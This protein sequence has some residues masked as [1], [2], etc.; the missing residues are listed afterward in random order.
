MEFECL[1]IPD[2]V[3]ITPKV[4]GDERGFFMET[5]RHTE[6]T[7]HCGEYI[8]VQDNHSRSR[9]GVLR[10]LHFQLQNPQ[11]KLIQ[12]TQGEVFDVAVD[13]R[14]HSDTFGAWVGVVLSDKNRKMLWVPPGFAHGFYVISEAAEFHYKCTDYYAP[15]DEHSLKWDDA[16]VG[17]SWP[18]SANQVPILSEKDRAGLPLESVAVFA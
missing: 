12:V 6:F 10:G 15:H 3:L 11:G 1:S 18:L 7:K 17:I 16:R 13:L 2:V 9:H 5:F 14:Q 4:H 8:F